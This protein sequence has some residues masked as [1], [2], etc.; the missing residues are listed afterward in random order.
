MTRRGDEIAE[1]PDPIADARDVIDRLL[2]VEPIA[3]AKGR[4]CYVSN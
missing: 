1:Q 2:G 3:D 4:T